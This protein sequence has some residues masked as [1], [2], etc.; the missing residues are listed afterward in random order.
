MADKPSATKDR[1]EASA[2][3]GK[4]KWNTQG[5]KSSYANVAN[6]TS[7]REEVVLNFGINQGWD[8]TPGELEIELTHRIILSPFAAKRLAEMLNKLMGEYE[9]RYGA[10][11][12]EA[13][14]RSLS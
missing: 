1:P 12:L 4:V 14:P 6:A 8:R 10:L 11:N 5:L 2:A 9:A 7:T 3:T 13:P